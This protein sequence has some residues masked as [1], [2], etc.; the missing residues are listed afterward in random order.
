[1]HVMHCLK[2]RFEVIEGLLHIHISSQSS[3]KVLA[4][5]KMELSSITID[6]EVK[7]D[8]YLYFRANPIG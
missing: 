4:F 2:T 8:G 1:M 5:F 3:H 6:N 7:R